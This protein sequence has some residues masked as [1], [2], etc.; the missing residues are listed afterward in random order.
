[1]S[2]VATAAHWPTCVLYVARRCRCARLLYSLY[3][4]VKSAGVRPD[5]RHTARRAAPR[6]ARQP[7]A[8]SLGSGICDLGRAHRPPAPR[9]A[10]FSG[11]R[12]PQRPW[13]NERR[14]DRTLESEKKRGGRAEARCRWPKPERE[15]QLR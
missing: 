10:P 4:T 9:G 13:S 7:P 1:M 14:R 6:G 5:T 2:R 11:N 3:C 12:N 8:E 15:P